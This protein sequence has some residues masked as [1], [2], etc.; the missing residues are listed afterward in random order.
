MSV[1]DSCIPRPGLALG[2]YPERES[3]PADKLDELLRQGVGAL[4]TRWE[5]RSAS[6]NTVAQLI[7][8][9]GQSLLAM[10]DDMLGMMISGL[11][12]QLARD[13]WNKELAVQGFAMVREMSAR[14]LGMRHF[15]SQIL[16]GWVIF[17]GKLAEMQ[18][19]EGKTLTATLPA[20]VAAM[21]GVPVHVIT[22]N[23]YLA[24]RDAQLMRPLYEALGLSVG[25]ITEDMDFKARRAAYHCDITDST[26][27]D[28]GLSVDLLQ[29]AS[30]VDSS[31]TLSISNITETSGN[32][33]SGVSV[34]GNTITVDTTSYNHLAVG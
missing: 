20:S 7:D 3:V 31:D 12:L 8:Q 13:G 15:D 23:D 27:E 1:R 33:A 34:V 9:A 10:P 30:D 32:D 6:L 25:V 26:L 19:G 28:D 11:R 22:S 18:T 5:S 16:G 2:A 29:N 17:N 21:A 4:T 24:S 14:T